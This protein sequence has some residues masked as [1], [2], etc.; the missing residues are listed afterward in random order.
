MPVEGMAGGGRDDFVLVGKRGRGKVWWDCVGGESRGFSS[1]K[2]KKF[3]VKFTIKLIYA[4]L[5][6]QNGNVRRRLLPSR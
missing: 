1:P 4:P 5:L 2:E 3:D 6:S